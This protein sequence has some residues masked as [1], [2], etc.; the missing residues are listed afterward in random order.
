MITKVPAKKFDRTKLH[1]RGGEFI[2]SEM[3]ELM[4]DEELVRQSV[5][6]L[7]ENSKDRN[8]ALLFASGVAHA[9]H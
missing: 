1:V 3:Q 5:A 4:D 7:I 2:A 6:E 8:S 9:Q